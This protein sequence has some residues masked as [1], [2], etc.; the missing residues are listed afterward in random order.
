MNNSCCDNEP[1]ET[2]SYCSN[3]ERAKE[4][5]AKASSCCGPSTEPTPPVN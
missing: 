2:S 4:S 1:K 3:E 5:E